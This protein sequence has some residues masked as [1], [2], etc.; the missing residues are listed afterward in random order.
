MGNKR[1]FTAINTKVRV[2]KSKLLDKKDYLQL[3]EKEGLR[4]QVNY[5]KEN[6]A[7]NEVLDNLADVDDIYEVEICLKRYFMH[8]YNKLIPYFTGEYRKL[9]KSMLLRFE[10]ED[11]KYFLRAL[12]R[13]DDLSRIKNTMILNEFYSKLDINK[14][15]KSKSLEE[16]IEGLKGTVYYNILKPYI[17]EAHQKILFYMEMNLDRFY[18]NLLKSQSLKLDKEDSILYG[19][20]LGK[21]IDLLNIQWIYRGL[22]FYSLSPEEL[23]NYTLPN[24]YEF[25]YEKIK[26]MCYSTEDKLKEI[27]LSSIYDFLF[28]TE[29]DIDL[30]MERRTERYLFYQFLNTFKRGR[31]DI[32]TVVAY[33]HLLEYEIRDIISILEAKKYGLSSDEIKEFLVRKIEGSD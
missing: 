28:D 14:L 12:D 15:S 3:M 1:R 24:G 23:I 29:N 19:E 17:N 30:F 11:I 25:N 4:S 8:Q 22:K 6:T 32:A 33:I 31:F 2:L 7:Y 13:K 18:F 26:K 21:N 27:V 10:I 9:L 16:F 20:M 5:L